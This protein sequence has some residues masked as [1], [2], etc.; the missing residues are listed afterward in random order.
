MPAPANDYG[1]TRKIYRDRLET[2]RK[3]EGEM[4]LTSVTG[5]KYEDT[6]RTYYDYA[7][8]ARIRERDRE[9]DREIERARERDRDHKRYQK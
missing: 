5:R 9:R 8:E 4:R 3:P 1:E 2:D 6:M 7:E